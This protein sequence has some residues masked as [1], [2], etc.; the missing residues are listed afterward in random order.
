MCAPLIYGCRGNR[1][2]QQKSSARTNL[3]ASAWWASA[4]TFRQTYVSL[5]SVFT[6]QTSMRKNKTLFSRLPILFNGLGIILGN[7]STGGRTHLPSC[8]EPPHPSR[9]S[10]LRI[11]GADLFYSFSFMLPVTPL[12]SPDERKINLSRFLKRKINL[13]RFLKRLVFDVLIGQFLCAGPRSELP[14]GSA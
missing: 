1:I 2:A 5:P 12:P 3:N 13:S 11:T 8:T 6:L 10:H 7:T 9:C 4:E 14:A